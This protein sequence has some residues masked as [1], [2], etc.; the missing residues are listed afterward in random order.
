MSEPT[1][2]ERSAVAARGVLIGPVGPRALTILSQGG[3]VAMTSREA[4]DVA[5]AVLA[6]IADV[7]GIAGVL[8]DVRCIEDAGNQGILR[9][10]KRREARLIAQALAAYLRA[11]S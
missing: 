5:D 1:M 4:Q 2:R 9:E 8:R 10:P 11:E 6:V 3:R 7:D